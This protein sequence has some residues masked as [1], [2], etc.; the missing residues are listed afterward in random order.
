MLMIKIS[1]D[2]LGTLAENISKGLRF[3]GKA[4]QCIDELQDEG[5]YGERRGYGRRDGDMNYRYPM[6]DDMG[7]R[8]D[9][10]GE[11]RG[12]YYGERRGRDSMG[13]Y[14]RM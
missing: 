9:Y 4:M 6:D 2:K 12:D 1:E 7:M 13:R 5:S 8:G 3:M 11:R 14:T 10:L